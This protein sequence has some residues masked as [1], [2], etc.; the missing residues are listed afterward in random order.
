MHYNIT[1][2]LRQGPTIMEEDSVEFT[3]RRYAPSPG[4]RDKIVNA[5]NVLEAQKITVEAVRKQQ[6]A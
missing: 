5:L 4:W 2:T 3:V 6:R 1:A